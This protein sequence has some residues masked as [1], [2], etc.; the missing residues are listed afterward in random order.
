MRHDL[1]AARGRVNKL[2]FFIH[3]FMD[4]CHLDPERIKACV[5]M[6]AT[7]NGPVSMCLYNARRDAS[8]LRPIRVQQV[9]G[10]WFWHPLT[11]ELS[12]SEPSIEPPATAAMRRKRRKVLSNGT[13]GPL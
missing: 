13:D 5:F 12:K 6:A 1:V 9:D 4:A 10:D 8:I 7:A 3:S 2:S 11:G